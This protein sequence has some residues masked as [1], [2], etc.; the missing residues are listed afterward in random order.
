[1]CRRRALAS[2]PGI[3]FPSLS[4][5]GWPSIESPKGQGLGTELL[6]DA[7]RRCL[8]LAGTLGIFA[9]EVH[10][11]DDE[12]RRFYQ[13]YGFLPLLDEERHLYLPIKTIEAE[14]REDT[15]AE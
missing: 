7:L 13:K 11:L 3:R 14:L 9:V 4:W 10:A 8:E 12:A 2:C 1:M 5:R 15:S 6:M